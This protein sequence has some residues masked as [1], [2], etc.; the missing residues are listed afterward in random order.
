MRA[1]RRLQ[2]LRG[3]ASLSR[4]PRAP[5]TSPPPDD[6]P[7]EAETGWAS[8][9]AEVLSMVGAR[10]DGLRDRVAAA[11]VCRHWR[12][13]L[14]RGAS[15]AHLELADSDGSAGSVEAAVGVLHSGR[16]LM[17][18]VWC[19]D[20]SV[21]WRCRDP[22]PLLRQVHALSRWTQL[23]SLSMAWDIPAA[24]AAAAETAA[25]AAAVARHL[26]KQRLTVSDS[27]RALASSPEDG[28]QPAVLS[29]LCLGALGRLTGLR[30]LS[31]AARL[32]GGK[33]TSNEALG[34]PG[35]GAGLYALSTLTRLTE[36]ELL[37]PPPAGRGVEPGDRPVWSH[38]DA[39][40]SALTALR[41]LNISAEFASP[42]LL[43]GLQA[44]SRLTRLILTDV[45]AVEYDEWH[46]DGDEWRYHEWGQTAD[47][48][49]ALTQL[50]LLSV[51]FAPVRRFTSGHNATRMLTKLAEALH[52]LSASQAQ[53]QAQQAQAQQ[54]QAQAQADAQAQGGHGSPQPHPGSAG[55]APRAS[56]TGAASDPDADDAAPCGP[57]DI[58]IDL[59]PALP[60]WPSADP[61]SS[62][63]H[64]ERYY[65]RR[66]ALE[67]PQVEMDEQMLS[68]LAA[69]TSMRRLGLCFDRG[70]A[71][72]LA[73]LSMLTRLT[74]LALCCAPSLRNPELT[75]TDVL[76]LTSS[77]PH[78]A[79][80]AVALP[81]DCLD[82]AALQPLRRCS[83]LTRLD[84]TVHPYERQVPY[85]RD[86][87]LDVTHR[88]N[89]HEVVRILRDY[90]RSVWW[91]C[92]T[93]VLAEAADPSD[94]IAVSVATGREFRAA[95][96]VIPAWIIL[97]MEDRARETDTH[98]AAAA[99]WLAEST[100]T[101]SE[102]A[103]LEAAASKATELALAKR[104]PVHELQIADLYEL[105]K[106]LVRDEIVKGAVFR[107]GAIVPPSLQELKL[108]GFEGLCF[109]TAASDAAS[110]AAGAG[111][112]PDGRRLAAMP[113]LRSLEIKVATGEAGGEVTE[114]VMA[115]AAE[116]GAAPSLQAADV[117]V[118][119]WE[120]VPEGG[121][122]DGSSRRRLYAA[123]A[124]G[125]P[126]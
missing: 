45:D 10:L 54:A 22:D 87:T 84:L 47:A 38:L 35:V 117:R 27:L 29:A 93:T 114:A 44:C 74:R 76:Q 46:F 79:S 30:R 34:P 73:M 81:A 33:D 80:L 63:S 92:Y 88:G 86:E 105:R 65:W 31:L 100:F 17:P 75:A 55:S 12:E 48:L 21:P 119:A 107:V 67:A 71:A 66:A 68:G 19:V 25:T 122:V 62:L 13:Q 50:R 41:S 57:L 26:T 16:V 64:D 121:R 104:V 115:W 72:N 3:G 82:A 9:S 40:L 118:E 1:Q 58:E 116:Q 28:R 42:P 18:Q 126:V 61:P 91:Q 106:L 39:H 95:M 89:A 20:V 96:P 23:Q 4:K 94:V 103:A 101:S 53:A 90:G 52:T 24:E 49:G 11:L 77:L 36:L 83:A 56:L 123:V 110:D 108:C 6:V 78:L 59:R 112:R 5:A 69:L 125:T 51:T 85:S 2:E 43:E 102:L 97:N 14:T 70:E 124:A 8:L 99:V 37:Q 120:G 60:T 7:I 32:S 15:H 109:G 111:A 113:R 98:A